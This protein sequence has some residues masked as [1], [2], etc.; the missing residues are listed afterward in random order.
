MSEIIKPGPL[1]ILAKQIGDA[2]EHDDMV[3]DSKVH[4]LEVMSE[5]IESLGRE[6]SC[7]DREVTAYGDVLEKV[8]AIPGQRPGHLAFWRDMH[9]SVRGI[10][11]GLTIIRAIDKDKQED[12]GAVASIEIMKP[13]RRV[14]HKIETGVDEYKDEYGNDHIRK[15]YRFVCV[16][17]SKLFPIDPVDAHSNFD[18]SAYPHKTSEILGIITDREGFQQPVN[19]LRDLAY[20]MNV[21]L[22]TKEGQ[23]DKD[24]EINHQLVSMVNQLNPFGKY[25]AVGTDYLIAHPRPYDNVSNIRRS[26]P[27]CDRAFISMGRFAILGAYRRDQQDSRIIRTIPHKELYVLGWKLDPDTLEETEIPVA[28]NALSVDDL[29]ATDKLK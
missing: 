17:G 25:R 27:E 15:N 10:Y 24:Q 5:S 19:V 2:A 1:D 14:A 21:Y 12:G 11:R 20:E 26:N 7:Y 18:L 16:S 4:D 13:I 23:S 3:R 9:G 28:I 8:P 6:F 29:V 22:N